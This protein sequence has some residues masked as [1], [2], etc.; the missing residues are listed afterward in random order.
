MDRRLLGFALVM[1]LVAVAA[2]GCK[3][4]GSMWLLRVEFEE[5]TDTGC[6]AALTENFTEAHE[7]E[8][9]TGEDTGF[10]PPQLT[11]TSVFEQSDGAVMAQITGGKEPV[12]V[13]GDQLWVGEADGS[14]TTFRWDSEASSTTTESGLGYNFVVNYAATI[15]EVIKLDFQGNEATGTFKT[16]QS[17]NQS[18]SETDEWDPLDVGVYGGQ[19]PVWA[20][21]VVDGK[22]GPMS[23]TNTAEEIEC[24]AANCELA[25]TSSC[26]ATWKLTATELDAEDNDSIDEAYRS[27]GVWWGGDDSGGLE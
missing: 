5:E 26:E 20:Y 12:L 24:A 21:L 27:P 6:E 22:H 4:D 10:E 17:S 15:A 19:M 1:G 7:P 8:G 18:W 14:T 3:R 16:T 23:A 25:L 11:V 2:A 13:I 9:D